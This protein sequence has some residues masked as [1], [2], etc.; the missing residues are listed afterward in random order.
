MLVP[1]AGR[2]TDD[3]AR[4]SGKRGTINSRRS[5]FMELWFRGRYVGIAR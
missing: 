2:A 5:W 4:Y 1:Y 3:L